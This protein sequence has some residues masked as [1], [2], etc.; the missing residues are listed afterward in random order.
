MFL[1]DRLA[2]R[3]LDRLF[4]GVGRDAEDVRRLRA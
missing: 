2:V 1:L 4:V 3:P